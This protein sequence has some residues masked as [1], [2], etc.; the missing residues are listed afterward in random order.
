MWLGFCE[1]KYLSRVRGW[2]EEVEVGKVLLNLPNGKSPAWDG[3]R[4]EV[5]QK[6]VCIL[7]RPFTQ[8]FQQR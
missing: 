2:C 6:Y 8:M 1:Y 7:K 3:I 4:N 5:C